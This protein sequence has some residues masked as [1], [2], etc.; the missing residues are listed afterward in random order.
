MPPRDSSF[1]G[2]SARRIARLRRAG[3][4]RAAV[5]Q[6]GGPA[7]GRGLAGRT[8]AVAVEAGPRSRRR[9][10]VHAVMVQV[11]TADPV[12]LVAICARCARPPASAGAAGLPGDLRGED[13]PAEILRVLQACPFVV[14]V[15]S[16]APRRRGHRAAEP[17]RLVPC[18]AASVALACSTS[19]PRARQ[20]PSPASPPGGAARRP[21]RLGP[22]RYTAARAAFAPWLPLVNF[23]AQL[24]HRTGPPQGDPAPSRRVRRPDA[25]DRRRDAAAHAAAAPRA[26]LALVPVTHQDHLSPMDIGNSPALALIPGSTS[27]LGLASPEPSPPRARTSSSPGD[28]PSFRASRERRCPPPSGSPSTSTSSRPTPSCRRAVEAFGAVDILV[29]NSGGSP[30][31]RP[32]ASPPT[33]S[34]ALDLLLSSSR[35]VDD[36]LPAMRERSGGGSS[37]SAQAACSQPIAHADPVQRRERALAVTSRRCRRRRR[38]RSHRQH[39]AARTHRHRSR[40]RAL[41][42]RGPRGGTEARGPRA[43]SESSIPAGRYGTPGRVRTRS[44]PFSPP[45]RPLRHRRAVPRRRRPRPRLLNHD[46]LTPSLEPRATLHLASIL[47]SGA[48]RPSSSTPTTASPASARSPTATSWP[49]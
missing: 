27:G 35:L 17:R 4:G 21:R 49:C 16:E 11:N 47:D 13:A 41:S 23:E 5:A 26:H 46:P 15:K 28:E 14:A 33:R 36:V 32:T 19:W 43:S 39:G 40:R 37:P 12:V 44:S 1:S 2:C 9:W 30:P 8:T 24:E 3:D 6:H 34:A 10:S 25:S 7:A 18:S 31:G 42:R 38:R 22:R 45:S 29:L 20:A 48:E